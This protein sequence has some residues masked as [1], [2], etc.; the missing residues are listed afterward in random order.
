MKQKIKTAVLFVAVALLFS[1]T[2]AAQ[3]AEDLTLYQGGEAYEVKSFTQTFKSD[4]P[5]NVILFIGDGMGVAQVFAG[6]TANKGSLFLENCRYIGFSK[7]SAANRYVTDSAA[8]GTALAT[9]KK[10]YNG[11]IGVDVDKNPVKNILKEVS[12]TSKEHKS[13]NR[14]RRLRHPSICASDFRP[15]CLTS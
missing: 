9:G 10:T 2:A 1:A 13:Q 12:E 8:G 7:T 4:T 6:L 3:Q 14:V 15:V 5:K 11:A